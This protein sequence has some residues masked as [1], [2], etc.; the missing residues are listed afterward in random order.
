M[1]PTYW[2]GIRNLYRWKG[3]DRSAHSGSFMTKQASSFGRFLRIAKI[4]SIRRKIS[5]VVVLGVLFVGNGAPAARGASDQRDDASPWGVASGAEWFSAYRIFNPLLKEAGVR[6]LRG[7]YEWQTIQPK[8]GYWNFALQDHLV[9]N[10]R[11]NNLHLVGT[12]AYLAPWASADG[13]T[14]RFPIKDIQFW[15]DYVAGMVE[16]YHADIKYWEVWNEF[17]GSFAEN[18]T[19]EI[20]AELVREA[21]VAAKKIDPTAK[22]GMSVAN[23][24]VN[25]LDRAIKAG[26]ANHFDYISV[27]PYEKLGALMFGGEPAFLA[28]AGVLREMLASNHQPTDTPLWITEIGATAPIAPNA[29]Q[30]QTQ[31][32]LLIKAYLLSI[33]SGFERVFW[34]EA[35]GPS[36]GGQADFGLLR[37]NMAPR[38]SYEALKAMTAILGPSPTAVGRIDL[39]DGSYGFLFDAQGKYVLSAWTTKNDGIEVTFAGDVRVSDLRS[40][41]HS[42]SAGAA[43]HLTSMPQL[44]L[45]IPD[46]LVQQAKSSKLQTYSLDADRRRSAEVSVRLQATNI[47]NGITQIAQETTISDNE[48]RRTNISRADG[49]GHYA[50]FLVN[51]QL[52]PFGVK[53]IQITATVRRLSRDRPAGFSIA[54]ESQRGYVDTS[55]SGIPEDEGWHE[56]S[57]KLTDASFVG[58][59]GWNFRLNAISSPNDFLIKEVRVKINP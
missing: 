11:A 31:A 43:L 53:E 41:L 32:N 24:D 39:G 20:Y 14:R 52:V 38:P 3:F 2:P 35:R 55:Y 19:P 16:R 7:F 42:L 50:Y 5:C 25:F 44:I 6:W 10:A 30:E 36:Y 47:G 48:S 1:F 15:R 4:S 56:I 37:A 9:A 13:G 34:F 23:F 12:L 40:E 57:W 29:S 18:G 22:I 8:Q 45:D 26:A 17:N 27:H 21:S 49:E 33:A 54:Y 58:Q 59:W 46:A 28:M 51:P